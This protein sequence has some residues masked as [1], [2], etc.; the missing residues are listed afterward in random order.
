MRLIFCGQV[1]KDVE[2]PESIEDAFNI[3]ARRSVVAISDGASESFDSKTW[4]NLLTAGFCHSPEIHAASI[5]QLVQNYELA[6][7][8]SSLTWSKIAAYERGSYATLLGVEYSSAHSAVDIFAIGDSVAA[9]I[10]SDSLLDTFPYRTALEFQQRPTLLSTRLSSNSFL[11]EHS[12]YSM[13]SITW[14]LPDENESFLILMTDALAEWAIRLNSEG[15]PRWRALLEIDSV[16]R[17]QTLVLTEREAGRMRTDD[18]TLVSL[19][20]TPKRTYDLP[21]S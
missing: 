20:F 10:Q 2:Y 1:P 9:L 8:L 17:L 13:H 5:K 18:V 3:D 14:E 19:G 11:D 6:H 15:S 4:A 21:I 16:S 7:D 12:F